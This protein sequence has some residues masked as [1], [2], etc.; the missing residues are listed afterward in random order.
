L[1]IPAAAAEIPV[2]PNNAAMIEIIKKNSAHL[3]I[4]PSA[5]EKGSADR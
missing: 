4:R 5:G 3:S 1:A 2:N